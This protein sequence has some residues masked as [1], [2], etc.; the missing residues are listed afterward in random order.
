MTSLKIIK[1]LKPL[2]LYPG[3]G[4]HIPNFE[5]AQA[6]ISQYIAHRQVRED[7][8]MK[9]LQEFDADPT[10]VGKRVEEFQEKILDDARKENKYKHE[11]LSGKP[12]VEKKKKVEETKEKPEKGDE[13]DGEETVVG[14]E[15][16]KDEQDEKV[17]QVEKGKDEEPPREET[18]PEDEENIENLFPDTQRGIPVSL[19]CRFIYQTDKESIIFAATKSIGAHLDK[20]EKEGKVS[21]TLV[22]LPKLVE[23]KVLEVQE[24]EGWWYHAS[25][26][27]EEEHEQPVGKVKEKMD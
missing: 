15:E 3:H 6:H 19:L 5:A 10:L 23:G 18:K 7:Q 17:V 1:A 14:E 26:Q 2:A 20:L 27:E 12:Y 24:Q 21:K 9:I 13:E 11:F 8:I 4:P 25:E 22:M 16:N